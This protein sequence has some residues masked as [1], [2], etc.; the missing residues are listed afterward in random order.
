MVTKDSAATKRR[1]LSAARAEFAEYGIAGARIARIAAAAACNKQLIYAYF[2]D[3]DGLYRAVHAEIVAQVTEA[4]PFDAEDLAGYA[5]RL[6]DFHASAPDVHRLTRW[7]ELERPAAAVS[8]AGAEATARKIEAIRRA[9]RAGKVTSD[10]A[11]DE[12]LLLVL[13]LAGLGAPGT[14][15]A[16]YNDD[17]ERFRRMIRRAVTDLVG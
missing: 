9:Q 14:P 11:A 15:E 4:V 1:I 17:P 5:V 7:A 6:F 8:A 12:I 3:K 10:R 13:G 2:G 16:A